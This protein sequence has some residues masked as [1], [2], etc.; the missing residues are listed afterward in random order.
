ME[1][2]KV[3]RSLRERV[4]LTV[5][6][7]PATL[8]ETLVEIEEAG[9][10]HAWVAG[11]P[12]RNPDLLTLLSAAAMRTTHLIMGTAIVQVFSRHP[13][14]LAQQALSFNALARG[15][16]RLGIGTSSPAFAKSMY[17]VEMEQP[18]AY[19]REY[20]QVLRSLLQE[21]EVHHQGRFFTIDAKLAASA[22]VPLLIAALGPVAFRLAGEIADGALPAA[23]PIPYLLDTALPAL[24]RSAASI[25][26][27]RP[28]I[29]AH[30]PV[31]L[32]E[33]RETAFQVGRQ[34]ISFNASLPTYRNMFLAAGFSEQEITTVSDH[35]IESLIVFGDES[36]IKDRLLELLG[37]EFDEL[38][39]SPLP[40]SD[41]VQEGIRL[42]RLIGQL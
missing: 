30:V 10:D 31:V 1:Q 37:T 15:R 24:R 2:Q 14:F 26:R 13:V 23:C 6:P 12:P 35:L 41:A 39:I 16:L 21:G 22:Q 33:D 7:N 19:L 17:G 11:G 4:S 38:R 18:L 3:E 20:V 28:P 40:V 34:A 29:V 5:D 25:G 36:K 42:A 32:T 9:V 27:E 8:V